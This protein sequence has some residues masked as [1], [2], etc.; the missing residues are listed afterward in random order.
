MVQGDLGGTSMLC[1]GKQNHKKKCVLHFRVRIGMN[2]N[3]Q[4][5]SFIG[6][7]IPTYSIDVLDIFQGLGYVPWKWDPY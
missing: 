3:H 4:K 7:L 5:R 2:N 6:T 1:Y